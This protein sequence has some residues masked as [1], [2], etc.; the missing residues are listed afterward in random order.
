MT[1]DEAI[2]AT[3]GKETRIIVNDRTRIVSV[4]HLSYEAVCQLAGQPDGATVIWDSAD[5]LTHRSLF[6]SD[7]PVEV[8]PLMRFTAVM[9][10][11]S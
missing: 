9:T 3:T 5:R 7:P 2:R 6:K 1:A 11:K 10:D 8:K 4:P